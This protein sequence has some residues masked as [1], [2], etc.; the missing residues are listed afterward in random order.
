M[1][2]CLRYVLTER[3]SRTSRADSPTASVVRIAPEQIAHWSFVRYFLDSVEGAD[4]I[5]R[6]D[7]RREAAVQTEDLVINQSGER[8]IVEE[9]CEEFPYV[10]IAVLSEAFI[11]EAVDLCDLARL[12]V[13]S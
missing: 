3:V 9:V 5:K 10:C 6:V 2:E 8:E 1:I 4:V 13:T 11:V 7:A 12:V